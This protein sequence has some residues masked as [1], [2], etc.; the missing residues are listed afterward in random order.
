[1]SKHKIEEMK[2][3]IEQN[4]YYM[5]LHHE[6]PLEIIKQAIRENIKYLIIGNFKNE[7]YVYKDFSIPFNQNYIKGNNYLNNIQFK[8]P[9]LKT[10]QVKWLCFSNNFPDYI[11]KYQTESANSTHN[12]MEYLLE[13]KNAIGEIGF[14]RRNGD[15][16]TSRFTNFQYIECYNCYSANSAINLNYSTYIGI[17]A[18]FA[19]RVYKDSHEIKYE[20]GEA[21]LPTNECIALINRERSQIFKMIKK[22]LENTFKIYANNKSNAR[23]YLKTSGE[24]TLFVLGLQPLSIDDE[25]DILLSRVID[26]VAHNDIYFDS[27]CLI[28]LYPLIKSFR[29]VSI[30]KNLFI[31]N[32]DGITFYLKQTK[33]PNILLSFGDNINSQNFYFQCL[34]ILYDRIGEKIGEDS[35]HWYQLGNKTKKGNPKSILSIPQSFTF[36]CF[37]IKEYLSNQNMLYSLI[38]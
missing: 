35:V 19:A 28:N 12:S 24:K 20:I 36:E 13:N 7:I 15:R 21:K 23:Y 5:I 26:I 30:D 27:L 32:L 8:N 1:M 2:M 10:T 6:Y 29:G 37:D 31:D 4:K 3:F 18:I 38:K 11:Y 22:K 14:I 25:N 9:D 33:E 17:Q 34:K 16:I